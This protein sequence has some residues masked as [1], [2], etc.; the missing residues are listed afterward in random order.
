MENLE[1]V[2]RERNRAF[3]E[4]ETGESGEFRYFYQRNIFCNMNFFC[5]WVTR[6]DER[7]EE[8]CSKMTLK[9]SCA[10]YIFS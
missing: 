2:V 4:L 9:F 3:F 10:V 1:F 5:E 8:T 6:Y 7:I